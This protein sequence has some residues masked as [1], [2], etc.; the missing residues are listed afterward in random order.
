MIMGATAQKAASMQI[1]TEF[2]P[3][4]KKSSYRHMSFPAR[5]AACWTFR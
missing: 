2:S 3:L 5:L 1:I 4:G